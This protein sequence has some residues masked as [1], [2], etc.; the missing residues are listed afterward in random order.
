MALHRRRVETEQPLRGAVDGGDAPV[1]VE[2][3][4]A[5]RH[6][7]QHRLGV[8]AALLHLG[9]LGL[10]VPV[11][12]LQLGLGGREVGGHPVERVH[13]D[14]DLVVGAHLD[15][16][17]EVARGHLPGALG[18]HLNRVGDAARQ[19]EAEPGRGEHDDQGHQEE[20]QDVDAL[21]RVLQ[22]AELLVLLEGLADVAQARLETLGHVEGHDHRARDG[23]VGAVADRHDGLDHVA[24]VQLVDGGDL[25]PGERLLDVLAVGLAGRHLGQH[26]ILD[27]HQLLA[28]AVEDRDRGHAQSVLLL[29]QVAGQALP[30]AVGEQAV[31]LDHLA[32]VAAVAEQGALQALVVGL[33]D[34][35]GLI[36]RPLHLG[37]EPPFDGRGD[38]VRRDQEDQDARHEGQGQEGQHELGLEPRADDLVAAL[39]RELDQVAEQQHQQQQEDD[40]V[41]VEQEEDDQVRR[42]RDL[43]RP[44]AHLEHGGHHQQDEDAR[45]DEQVT[46]ALLLL[47]DAHGPAGE[48]A[49]WLR[50]GVRRL[51]CTHGVSAASPVR[52][53]NQELTPPSDTSERTRT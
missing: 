43:W 45:N 30:P 37:L 17:A 46:L 7:L 38:E 10:Q 42:E 35:H 18:Q 9:V 25:L 50:T 47:V 23:G 29:G 11:G 22:Q 16:V 32:H 49:H 24:V 40:Q 12:L 33:R 53:A 20:E 19:V 44:D 39:E 51:D 26:R 34:L 48:R 13:Q 5:G 36:E 1:R 31:A 8:A 14:A 4:H 52:R 27:V 15:L 2:R 21:D 41:Q 28:V 3:D 6:R